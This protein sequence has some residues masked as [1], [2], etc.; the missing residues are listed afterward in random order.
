MIPAVPD[1][2]CPRS[3]RTVFDVLAS[4]LPEDWTVIHSRRFTLPASGSS[5][6]I[7]C[8]VDF[9]ILHPGRGVLGLE[10]KGGQ[11]I[12]RSE[13]GWYS[14]DHQGRR[15]AIRD[16]GRQA[17]RAIH[18]VNRY[19]SGQREFLD[20]TL[21]F[22][23]AVCFPDVAVNGS[24]DPAL[25]REQVIDSTDLID[26]HQRMEQVFAAAGM[27][28]RSLSQAKVRAFVRRLAPSFRLAPSLA[29]RFARD[30]AVLVRMT[31]D[32]ADVLD[33]FETKH[34]VAVRGAAG[35]GKTLV[36]MEKARRLAAA[37]R[38]VVFLCFNRPLADFLADRAQDFHVDSFHGLA[39]EVIEQAGLNHEVPQDSEA[40]RRFWDEDVAELFLQ[41][42]ERS[43]Q[44]RWDAVIVDEAQDFRADWWIP[45]RTLL[46]CPDKGVLYVFYDPNQQ[47]YGDGPAAELGL[48]EVHLKYN[49]R[50]TRKIAAVSTQPVGIS[51][52]L[53][54]EMP[55]G[56][57]VIVRE[58]PTER[59]MIDAVRRVLHEVITVNNVSSDRVVVLSPR[60][61]DHSAVY[62]AGKLG[63]FS[64]V[65]LNETPGPTDVRFSTLHRFKGLEADVVILCDV[66]SDAEKKSP[67][68]LYVAMSRPRHLLAVCR[69]APG[70][71]G[72]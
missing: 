32:Q 50:N 36:A 16:P 66:P 31:D 23:W 34:Q 68:H 67:R 5:R 38:Q 28:A 22:G 20:G 30:D 45:V 17:Q 54:P 18:C 4:G 42:L 72:D 13:N 33:L 8:E 39:M 7:E 21:P 51:P 55:E 56:A 62:G 69:Y 57:D 59:D 53:K 65:E 70:T 46:R 60:K 35:T 63:N 41:A 58:C 12:G 14:V 10:V 52:V 49:C 1:S 64:L 26:I 11:D 47:I 71:A 19:L 3:E 48:D 25:P 24:P 37:G 40:R 15:H 44:T 43:P 29:S 2:D 6:S 9:L 27:P 61:P